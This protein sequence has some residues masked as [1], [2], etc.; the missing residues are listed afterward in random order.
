M[1]RAS[2]KDDVSLVDDRPPCLH[3]LTTSVAEGI[4]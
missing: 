1:E 2:L 4:V 3:S